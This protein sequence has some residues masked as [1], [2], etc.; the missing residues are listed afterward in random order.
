MVPATCATI[1]RAKTW[2]GEARVF[3]FGLDEERAFLR[4][5]GAF[6]LSEHILLAR[7]RV[8]FGILV[9]EAVFLAG[10]GL[11]GLGYG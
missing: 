11:G 2:G 9:L 5:V 10:P 6:V 4:A 3:L 7:R 1:P 8:G